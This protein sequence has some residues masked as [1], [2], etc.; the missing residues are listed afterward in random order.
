MMKLAFG[1]LIALALVLPCTT[2]AADD[3]FEVIWFMTTPREVYF[4][5]ESVTISAMACAST[6]L[7]LLVPGEMALLTVR[8]SSWAETYSVWL[9]TNSNGTA[10]CS[11]DIPL[12]ADTG[13]Y[14]IILDP[15]MGDN[16]V[17]PFLVLFDEN[18]YWQKRVE[19]LEDELR[20]QYEYL[21]YLYGTSNY[22]KRQVEIL[23]TQVFIA[24]AVMF[25]TIA[26]TM[27]VAIPEWARRSNAPDKRDSVS[28]RFA[29]LLGFT[30][31]P[32]VLLS[33]YHEEL[34]QLGPVEGKRSPRF[35][36]DY[37][38]HICD[39]KKLESMTKEFYEQ[40]MMSHYKWLLRPSKRKSNRT[41]KDLIQDRYE[42]PEPGIDHESVLGLLGRR[43]A[44]LESVDLAKKE[45]KAI[46]AEERRLDLKDLIDTPSEPSP[47]R[48]KRAEKKELRASRK[49]DKKASKDERRADKKGARAEKK[50]EKQDLKRE[51]RK[52]KKNKKAREPEEKT[53]V[54][55]PTTIRRTVSKRELQGEKAQS[56]I[57]ERRVSKTP[58]KQP[59]DRGSRTEIDEL[60]DKLLRSD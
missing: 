56:G 46:A 20:S 37:Y 16:V 47:R 33:P 53:P 17:L 58:L 49:Q 35:G 15:V 7:T 43:Q 31:E 9:T 40:H 38:C 42:V 39:P 3:E 51:H 21:N 48:Q 19:N 4:I 13:N 12:E 27:L 6:D 45:L 24:G 32:K 8:N 11:W 36:H 14:T 60:Y 10:V 26:A 44:L 5:G 59:S 28:G 2:V 57:R 25:I 1:C 52:M 23:K 34:A 22:L 54:L 18:T 30:T 29:R 50:A 41:Y 55:K